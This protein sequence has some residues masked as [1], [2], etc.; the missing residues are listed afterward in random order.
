MADAEAKHHCNINE[1]SL[2]QHKARESYLH[3]PRW[4]VSYFDMEGMNYEADVSTF[5]N[6]EAYLSKFLIFHW[7]IQNLQRKGLRILL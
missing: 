1:A 6:P 4:M 7:M 5:S 2:V 3:M